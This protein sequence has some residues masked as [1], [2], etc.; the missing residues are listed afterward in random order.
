M[1]ANR[2]GG[3]TLG[4]VAALAAPFI[5]RK[6]RDRRAQRAAVANTY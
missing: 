4:S 3:I 1:F 5:W 6:L 2:R